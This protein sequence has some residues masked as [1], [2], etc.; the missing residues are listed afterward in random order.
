L[1][2]EPRDGGAAAK[3]RSLVLVCD[4]SEVEKLKRMVSTAFD[5]VLATR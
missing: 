4:P 2:A 5:P 3:V 1:K